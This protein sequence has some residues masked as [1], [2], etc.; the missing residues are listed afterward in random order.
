MKLDPRHLIQLSIIVEAGSFQA[1]AEQLGLSQPALSRN[2]STL[3]ARLAGPVF[4]RSGRRAVPTELG[5][6]LAR[7]GLTIRQAREQA[8]AYADQAYAGAAG[9]LRIGA[10]PIVAGRFITDVLSSL[11]VDNPECICEI[12]VGLVHELRAMLERGRIDFVIGPR[13][14]ADPRAG[15]GFDLIVNDR[16]GIL[17]NASHPLTRIQNLSPADLE[18]QAWI[19][20]SRGSLLRQQTEAALV[21]LG[22]EHIHIAC[23]TDSIRTALEIVENTQ[24][25][26]TMP[27]ETTRP[28]LRSNL[29]FL[30]VDHPQFSR[31][32][33]IV[34]RNDRAKS[35]LESAF[36]AKLKNKHASPETFVSEAV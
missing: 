13:G 3:E 5:R 32:L 23:E 33:G 36:I 10:P 22:I 19:A 14:I 9:Q 12:R 17:C 7:A 24:M 8:E 30:D 35:K 11:L 26:S 18:K 25:I 15:L 34:S 27:K 1:A 4:D 29:K 31:P 16:V 6:R 21:A 20:H 2:I 28:Y